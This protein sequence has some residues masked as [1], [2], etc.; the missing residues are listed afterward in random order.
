ML[1]ADVG[2]NMERVDF[3]RAYYI[4]LGRGGEWEQSSI[5]ESKL[6]IGWGRQ[7]VQDIN[8]GDWEKIGEELRQEA[9][10]RKGV[11][12]RDRNALRWICESTSEDLW[13]TFSGGRMWWCRLGS[14]GILQDAISKYRL[15]DGKWFD[16][17][18]H[19]RILETTSIPGELSKIQGFRGTIC[20][21]KE[22]ETL[23]R[24][25]ND[26][27]SSE[28]KEIQTR[29]R[30]L[31]DSVA[32]GIKKLH[33][34]DFETFVDLVFRGSGWRRLSMLGGTMKTTDL[35]LEDPI[36]RDQYKVQVKS[37]A[38]LEDFK[39][40]LKQSNQGPHKKRYFVVHSPARQ[41]AARQ[42]LPPDVELVLPDRLSEMAVRL[43]LVD[44]LLNHIK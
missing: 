34:K 15:V 10:G 16:Q 1:L 27:P 28:Y 20:Q 39:G 9:H 23:R 32:K 31:T 24:L 2:R 3:K 36:T 7:D 5:S 41:L 8:V 40:F 19:G 43:G 26:E 6:R 4:K 21:V 35:E 37:Q 25:V 38:T 33:W 42:L 44:W 14:A 17:D 13:I 18:I 11:A 29:N 22:R 12:T 30:A